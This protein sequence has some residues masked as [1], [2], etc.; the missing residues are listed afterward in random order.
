MVEVLVLAVKGVVKILMYQR[1]SHCHLHHFLYLIL[2]HYQ[3]QNLYHPLYR[4]H[5]NLYQQ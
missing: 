2:Y 4:Q 3:E 1:H 5:Q